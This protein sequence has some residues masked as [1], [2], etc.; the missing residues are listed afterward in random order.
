MISSLQTH[1]IMKKQLLTIS[2]LSFFFLNSFF[3]IGQQV[4]PA[5]GEP[6]KYCGTDEAMKALFDNNPGLKAEFDQLQAEAQRNAEKNNSLN[7]APLTIY[8]IP[9]VV[10]VLHNYGSE[11]ISD[12]QVEDA[13]NILSRDYQ[14]Q[15]ADTATVMAAFQSNIANVGIVFA[16][17]QKD[18]NGN[19]TNGIDRIVTQETYIGDDNSKL[20]QWPRNKYLNIWTAST[21][22]NGAAGYSYYPSATVTNPAIDGVM[23]LSTYIG[24]IGTGNASTSR[25][26]T[27]EVGHWMNLQHPWG[28]TN[29]PGVACGDDGV[30][31]TPVTK[32]WTSCNL[33][34]A[35]AGVCTTGVQEN[36]ENYMDYAYC[37]KM[38]TAGQK[39]RMLSAL[40]SST[41][42]RNNLWSSSNL[43]ATGVTGTPQLC[44][45]DFSASTREICAGS[46]VTFTDLSWHATP[47]SWQWDVDNDGT[48]DYTTQNPTHTYSTPGIYTVKLTVSDGVSTKSETK[49]SYIVVLGSSATEIPNY[50]QGFET[51]GF[52]YNDCFINFTNGSGPSW[53]QNTGASYSGTNCLSINNFSSTTSYVEEAIFPSIDLTGATNLQ[54]NFRVAY[55]QL[56]STDAS[57]LRVLVS[58]NCGQTWTQKYSKS[59]GSLATAGIVATSFTPSSTSQWRLEAPV[60]STLAGNNNVRFKFEFTGGPGTGNNIYID[61]INITSGNSG[62][63]EEY[64]NEFGFTVS[65]NPVFENATLSFSIAQRNHVQLIISDILGRTIIPLA[66]KEMSAGDHT[67][68]VDRSNLKPGIYL[69][70]LNVNGYIITKKM[71]VQ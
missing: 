47:T 41:A 17:A 49:T 12:A 33:A 10:H 20:N 21:L 53:T 35:T 23:I 66:D 51:A 43:T 46:S 62:I 37:Q 52:P 70:K 38:F 2:F 50:S 18:P 24:S 22:S 16:L 9:V 44:F 25:A 15:N 68:P 28:S 61:D 56:A 64:A 11:N 69:A 30:T 3:L 7:P 59:G 54:M 29:Q 65:P 58:T 67:F 31:D 40:T 39:S 8:T 14:K 60:I 26:L 42:G 63:Q 1:I 71:I 5:T 13:V 6:L 55:A 34:S 4:N 27:H 32:G 48:V 45:A 19:C 36:I 57:K